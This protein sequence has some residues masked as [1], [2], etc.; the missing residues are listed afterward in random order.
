MR[1]VYSAI[2]LVG[3]TLRALYTVAKRRGCWSHNLARNIKGSRRG[4]KGEGET[5]RI[6]RQKKTGISRGIRNDCLD[7]LAFTTTITILS[8]FY[9]IVFTYC[10]AFPE[11]FVAN[12]APHNADAWSFPRRPETNRRIGGPET[13]RQA[14]ILASDICSAL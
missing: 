1:N 6:E 11:S 2:S 14:V 10:T 7:I 5:Q 3:T 13:G 8:P 4:E 12:N 9:F